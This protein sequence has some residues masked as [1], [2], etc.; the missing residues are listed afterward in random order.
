MQRECSRELTLPAFP[1]KLTAMP[2]Q[3]KLAEFT[4][5]P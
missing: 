2:I 4:T 5:L 1:R 3:E